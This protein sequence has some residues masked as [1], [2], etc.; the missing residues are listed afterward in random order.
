ML[1]YIHK[2]NGGVFIM[3]DVERKVK[4]IENLLHKKGKYEIE[5]Y[6]NRIEII[7]FGSLAKKIDNTCTIYYQ[8]QDL[9]EELD[10]EFDLGRYGVV[11]FYDI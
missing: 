9:A 5:V 11:V 3:K 6:D 10:M 1:L 7:V 2:V 8:L 4:V